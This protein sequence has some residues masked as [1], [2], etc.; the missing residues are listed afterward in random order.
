MLFS[1]SLGDGGDGSGVGLVLCGDGIRRNGAFASSG[2][3][4]DN[5]CVAGTGGGTRAVPSVQ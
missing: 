2:L 4:G 3:E 1:S 5:R